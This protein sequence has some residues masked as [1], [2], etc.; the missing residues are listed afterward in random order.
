MDIDDGG[1][2]NVDDGTN[3]DYASTTSIAGPSNAVQQ[4]LN[5]DTYLKRHRDLSFPPNKGRE[6]LDPLIYDIAMSAAISHLRDIYLPPGDPSTFETV[7]NLS[8]EEW[9][10][11]TTAVEKHDWETVLTARMCIKLLGIYFYSH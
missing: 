9:I 5:W 7:A 10:A 2:M 4:A 1:A 6:A 11:W 3:V 8:E